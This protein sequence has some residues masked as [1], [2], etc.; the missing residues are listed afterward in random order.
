MSQNFSEM[1]NRNPKAPN[2]E[3]PSVS[4]AFPRPG[5]LFLLLRAQ[6]KSH[7]FKENTAVQSSPLFLM[8]TLFLFPC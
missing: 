3:S 7:L 8:F 4:V 6:H 1:I 2:I 5:W